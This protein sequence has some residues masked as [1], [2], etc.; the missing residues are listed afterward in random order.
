MYIPPAIQTASGS[1][2]KGPARCNATRP[3][4]TDTSRTNQLEAPRVGPILIEQAQ[5]E[6]LQPQ[7]QAR[8][9]HRSGAAIRVHFCNDEHEYHNDYELRQNVAFSSGRDI[10]IEFF[11][12][13]QVRRRL[14]IAGLHVRRPPAGA[15]E[16]DPQL[17][18][19]FGRVPCVKPQVVVHLEVGPDRIPVR[20]WLAYAVDDRIVFQFFLKRSEQAIPYDQHAAVVA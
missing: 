2:A 13:G 10:R 5:S 15:P 9:K 18:P 4:G 6:K 12:Y 14:R 1:G 19:P 20:E 17:V 3:S 8:R 7:Y 16:P 11:E